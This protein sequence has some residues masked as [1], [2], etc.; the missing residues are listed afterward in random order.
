MIHPAAY[1]DPKAELGANVSVGPN[2]FVGPN[3]VVGD[4]CVLHNNVTLTGHARIG[5]GCEFYPGAVVGTPPQDLKYRGGPT[6]VEIGD[7]NVFREQVTVHAGT[8]V[9]GGRTR[10][11]QP[12][13]CRGAPG[14]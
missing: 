11:G 3:V 4:N 7:D 10:I 1:V 5:V 2:S 9:A 12:V 13:P 14:P 8:E 6:L